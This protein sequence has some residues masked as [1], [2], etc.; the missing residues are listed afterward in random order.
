MRF[1]HMK[2]S[3][4][5]RNTCKNQPYE[6]AYRRLMEA[7]LI[8]FRTRYMPEKPVQRSRIKRYDLYKAIFVTSRL[9]TQTFNFWLVYYNHNF[10]CFLMTQ[11]T[12]EKNDFYGWI[13][14][15]ILRGEY[16]F[17]GNPG[18]IPAT[19]EEDLRIV[20]FYTTREGVIETRHL[21]LRTWTR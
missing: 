21:T 7:C 17:R 14:H 11:N 13:S 6:L 2:M 12:T 5:I 1:V 10:H 8:Y 19:E 15:I 16:N 9:K 18:G 3:E 4:V 20:T